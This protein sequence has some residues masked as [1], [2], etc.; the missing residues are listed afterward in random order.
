MFGRRAVTAAPDLPRGGLQTAGTRSR[1]IEFAR[2]PCP[3]GAERMD[4][5][6]ECILPAIELTS[7]LRRRFERVEG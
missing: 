4:L 6:Y 1:V 2:K 7:P 3:V 5:G